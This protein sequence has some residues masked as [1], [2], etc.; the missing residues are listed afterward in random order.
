M[1][2]HRIGEREGKLKGLAVDVFLSHK[3]FPFTSRAASRKHT[4]V[5]ETEYVFDVGK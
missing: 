3:S 2:F 1:R 4:R 5:R